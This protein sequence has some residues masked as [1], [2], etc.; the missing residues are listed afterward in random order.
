MEKLELGVGYLRGHTA[1]RL[2]DHGPRCRCLVWGLGGS[3]L[4]AVEHALRLDCLCV[5]R[6]LFAFVEYAI[7]ATIKLNN[8]IP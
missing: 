7:W 6:N 2:A 1:R 8:I 3:R 4:A 5:H